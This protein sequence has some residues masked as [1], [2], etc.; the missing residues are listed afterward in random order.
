MRFLSLNHGQAQPPSF[1]CS[2]LFKELILYFYLLSLQPV[3]CRVA[4]LTSSPVHRPEC[5]L[6]FDISGGI[7]RNRKIPYV[8]IHFFK[9]SFTIWAHFDF[10]QALCRL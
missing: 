5:S 3:L 9:Q 7:L 8:K 10:K 6:Y 1:E 4:G 2:L